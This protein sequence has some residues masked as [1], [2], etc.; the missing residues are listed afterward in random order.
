MWT[1]FTFD[2]ART[3]VRAE[4]N[5][6]FANVANRGFRLVETTGR[7]PRVEARRPGRVDVAIDFWM[8]LDEKGHYRTEWTRDAP[9]ELGGSAA[10]DLQEGVERYRYWK[11][12]SAY[13]KRPYD[14]ALQSLAADIEAV[15]DILEAW[16]EDIV[17]RTGSRSR[18]P[19]TPRP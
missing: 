1:E 12:Y 11:A 16:T 2:A 18:L 5:P 6:A 3:I 17:I 9:F 7:Y 10:V 15:A 14:L 19:R 4:A 13:G 8:S